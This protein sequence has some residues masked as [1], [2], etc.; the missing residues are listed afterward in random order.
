MTSIK[1]LR[2]VAKRLSKVIDKIGILDN[3]FY[4]NSGDGFVFLIREIVEQ[5][6]SSK[7]KKMLYNRLWVLCVNDTSPQSILSFW[8]SR[9]VSS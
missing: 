6:I 8:V 2:K 7:V 5:I 4:N 3:P 1:H 9:Q